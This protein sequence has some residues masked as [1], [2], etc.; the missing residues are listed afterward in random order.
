M[1]ILRRRLE[2][3]RRIYQFWEQISSFKSWHGINA[4][5]DPIFWIGHDSPVSDIL[6]RLLRDYEDDRRLLSIFSNLTMMSFPG[7]SSDFRLMPDLDDLA[8]AMFTFNAPV[9]DRLPEFL[10]ARFR[11]Y[12]QSRFFDDYYDRARLR[13]E[14][15]I[16]AVQFD[17]NLALGASKEFQDEIANMYSLASELRLNIRFREVGIPQLRLSEG[18]SVSGGGGG[19]GTIGGFLQDGMSGNLFG[20]TCGHVAGRKGSILADNSG[21]RFNVID[22]V[23]P[24]ASPPG[25]ICAPGHTN[26]LDVALVD[27]NSAAPCL[28]AAS[29]ITSVPHPLV[30]LQY[31]GASTAS[32]SSIASATKALSVVQKFHSGTNYFCFEDTIVFKPKLSPILNPSISRAVVRGPLPGDSGAWLLTAGSSGTEWCGLI[33][34]SDTNWSE[35]YAIEAQKIIDWQAPNLSLIVV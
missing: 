11:Y 30:S 24:S 1:E 5:I 33:I 14:E 34:G 3:D 32:S 25:V 9:L 18:D 8:S 2:E 15:E 31:N 10:D 28:N 7:H 27:V 20:V 6:N 12:W 29:G 21:N 4:R 16:D 26:E 23:E 17:L 22:S 19:R 13:K 35:G